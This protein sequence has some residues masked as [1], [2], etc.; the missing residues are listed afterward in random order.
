M[1]LLR[2]TN[3][4]FE[5]IWMAILQFYQA[6]S[7]YFPNYYKWNLLLLYY[8]WLPYSKQLTLL[9]SF[10]FKLNNDGDDYNHD[11]SM[12]KKHNNYINI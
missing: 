11:I 7:L 12:I 2:F 1:D 10:K 3:V 5:C 9:Y 4:Y 8:Y 6:T